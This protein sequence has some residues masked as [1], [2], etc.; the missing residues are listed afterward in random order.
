MQVGE[1]LK[2]NSV[3]LRILPQLHYQYCPNSAM[4][5]FNQ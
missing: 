3:H 2:A 5:D 4:A 1:K